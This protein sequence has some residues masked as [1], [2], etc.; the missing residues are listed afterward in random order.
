MLNLMGLS[1]S[2][3]NLVCC[4]KG[5]RAPKVCVRVCADAGVRVGSCGIK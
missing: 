4:E 2:Y 5:K 3:R 1:D